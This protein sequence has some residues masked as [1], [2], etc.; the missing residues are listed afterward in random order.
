[1]GS[2]PSKPEGSSSS[3]ASSSESTNSESFA[4]LKSR[5]SKTRLRVLTK[6]SEFVETFRGQRVRP[7]EW[8]QFSFVIRVEDPEAFRCGWTV[9]RAVGPAVVRNQLKRW[10]R[11]WLREK[12]KESKRRSEAMPS[13]SLNIGF[14]AVKTPPTFYRQMQYKDFSHAMEKAWAAMNRTLA[15]K[16]T[17]AKGSRVK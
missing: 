4:E 12:M 15:L 16:A 9:P 5:R 3:P 14:S 17:K 1:M 7:V 8:L 6:R 13:V 2:T 11:E 10:S